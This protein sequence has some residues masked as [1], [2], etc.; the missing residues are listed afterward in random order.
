MWVAKETVSLTTDSS[1]N[2]TGYT[3]AFR[4]RLL[5]IVYTK[6]DFAAGVDFAITLEDT[7]LGLWTES[8]VNASKTVAP[9]Q[10]T[11]DQV[12]ADG[13]ARD[14]VFNPNERVKIVVASGGDT[15]SGSFVVIYG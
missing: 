7:G 1:G 14:Y 4:G 10:L 12:G 11:Q 9:T 6:D 3:S 8:N 13:T 15:K 2:A 5:N